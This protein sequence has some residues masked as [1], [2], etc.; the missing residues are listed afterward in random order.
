MTKFKKL[1]SVSSVVLVMG[2]TSITAFAASQYKTPAEAVAGITGRTIESVTTERYSS[3]K[4]YGTIASEAGKLE[5]FKVESLEMKKDN[6]ALQVASGR[7]TQA[8]ADE[9]IKAIEDNQVNCD[10]TG[11]ARIGAGMG[12]GFGSNGR[13]TGV[14]AGTGIGSGTARGGQGRGMGLR[15]N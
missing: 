6:L 15:A 5:E 3:N 7:L 2:A 1:V 14:G 4:T 11:T 13:G 9:I 8:Q 10:G 12:A